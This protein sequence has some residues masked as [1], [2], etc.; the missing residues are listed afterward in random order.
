MW[1]SGGDG[2]DGGAVVCV[3]GG[4]PV[5]RIAGTYAQD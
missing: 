1:Q 5:C 2:I 3:C 4:M